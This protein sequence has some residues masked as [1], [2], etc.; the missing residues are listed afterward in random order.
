MKMFEWKLAISRLCESGHK[1]IFILRWRRR[2]RACFFRFFQQ[3]WLSQKIRWYGNRRHGIS[4]WQNG[5][6]W[7]K[8]RFIR[9]K[10]C[11]CIHILGKLD[12]VVLLCVY[13]FY[14]RSLSTRHTPIK[15]YAVDAREVSLRI[16]CLPT[17]CFRLDV[18]HPMRLINMV[19][20]FS[21]VSSTPTVAIALSLLSL[22]V[23]R[24]QGEINEL[25]K[26]IICSKCF[27]AY[28]FIR[29]FRLQ[30]RPRFNYTIICYY[31]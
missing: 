10:F 6:I 2:K 31:F 24:I 3:I 29:L 19:K 21:F 23:W 13:E 11:L 18:F 7:K 1:N 16:L 28:K 30:R 27:V 9:Y 17:D 26:I 22:C 4:K 5:F 25:E 8:P 14:A 20:D 12:V 15:L